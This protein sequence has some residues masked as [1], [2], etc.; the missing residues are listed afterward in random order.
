MQGDL[1][2]KFNIL[3]GDLIGHCEKK[4]RRNMCLI[5]N[6]YQ[7]WVVLKSTNTKTFWMLIKKKKFI[8]VYL[9]INSI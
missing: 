8:Y 4:F 3:A 2:K 7:D 1:G 6:V 5:R 9:I